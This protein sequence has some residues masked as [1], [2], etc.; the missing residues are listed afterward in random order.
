MSESC[1]KTISISCP[2]QEPFNLTYPS[3]DAAKTAQFR[4]ARSAKRCSVD[5]TAASGGFGGARRR[6]AHKARKARRG[7]RR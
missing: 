6:K 7:K 2:G 4:L 5:F 1:A 3:C